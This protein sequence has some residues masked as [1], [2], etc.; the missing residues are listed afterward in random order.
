VA[1]FEPV[2]APTP[3]FNLDSVPLPWQE[4]LGR[5]VFSD[6]PL[7]HGPSGALMMRNLIAHPKVMTLSVEAIFRH[8]LIQGT[9][10]LGHNSPTFGHSISGQSVGTGTVLFGLRFSDG[11]RLRN[12]DARGNPGPLGSPLG[13]GGGFT[14]SHVFWAPL[15]SPGELEIWVAWPATEIPE[16]RTALDGSRVIDTA[17]AETPLWT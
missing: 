6:V 11:T 14:G 2:S 8:P 1:F 15:P 13:S 4:G 12:L 16:T 5:T 7:A 9:G 3:S 10:T 17:A